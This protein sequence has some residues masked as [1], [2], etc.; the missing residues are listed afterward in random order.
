MHFREWAACTDLAGHL[1]QRP[2]PIE[3][4][5]RRRSRLGRVAASARKLNQALAA[6]D[7]ADRGNTI[8]YLASARERFPEGL[9]APN[10]ER[11]GREFE[12]APDWLSRLATAADEA[13][14]PIAP[15]R[16]R[17][18]DDVPYLVLLDIAAIFEWATDKKPTRQVDRV[19][20]EGCGGFHCFAAAIWPVVFGSGDDGLSSAIQSWA[21]DQKTYNETSPL[22]PSIDLRYGRV[23]KL[24]E[25][26]T[27]DISSGQVT[28][29]SDLIK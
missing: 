29:L 20:S 7:E 16:G 15:R 13:G 27:A 26:P 14:E 11:A 2:E 9:S 23:V 6:L 5:T 25:M 21:A 3:D 24:V 10:I 28:G 1:R 12:A 19:T 22:I 17:M 4:Q 8:I 18:R